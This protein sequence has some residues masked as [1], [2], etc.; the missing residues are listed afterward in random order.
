M[1]KPKNVV[2]YLRMIPD[3]R[4][5]AGQRHDQTFVLLIVL[6]GT[7][8]GYRGYRAMGDFI[9]RNKKDLLL[10]FKPKKD[11]LPSFD[12][13]RRVIQDLDFEDLSRQFHNWALQ[14]VSISKSEWI[15]IDGKAIGGTT[16]A[17]YDNKQRFINL[18]SLYCSKQKIVIGNAFVDNSKESEIPVVRQ[19]I[20]ALDIK[21]VTFTLDA[22]HCQK[23]RQKSSSIV[24]TT[25]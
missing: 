14:Y 22:L 4:R 9:T 25:M 5:T 2:D 18:V 7:M 24:A 16:T 11:R 20:E 1:T 19:L 8:S 23:K 17:Y 10:H 12:T 21:D 15:S 3:K 6:M 13:I